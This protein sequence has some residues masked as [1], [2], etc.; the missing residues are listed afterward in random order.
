MWFYINNDDIMLY[1]YSHFVIF[2][3]SYIVYY[4][5]GQNLTHK[6][7]CQSQ[8]LSILLHFFLK[9]TYGNNNRLCFFFKILPTTIC[10][11]RNFLTNCAYF[12]KISS[13]K[14]DLGRMLYKLI[15]NTLILL[16]LQVVTSIWLPGGTLSLED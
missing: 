2:L 13:R 11:I 9:M 8:G 7:W 12:T 15:L 4:Y 14:L 6:I 10:Y 1:I 16:I 5:I 3:N